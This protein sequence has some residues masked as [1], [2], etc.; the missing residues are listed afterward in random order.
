[1]K[2]CAEILPFD[3]EFDASDMNVDQIRRKARELGWP[4]VHIDVHRM[5]KGDGRTIVRRLSRR[6][7]F[8][9]A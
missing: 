8:G 1:M 2:A 4:G 7:A 9:A 5:L 3:V 6:E